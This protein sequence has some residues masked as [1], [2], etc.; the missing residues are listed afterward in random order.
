MT[1]KTMQTADVKDL[2]A[3]VAGF[4]RDGG[5]PRVKEIV[6]RFMHDVFQLIEDFDVSPEEFWQA[7]YYVNRLGQNGEAA[8]LAPGLGMDRYLDIRLDARDAEA[9]LAGGTPRTIE[10]PLYVAGAPL[11]EGYARMDDG[12]DESAEVMILTGRVTDADGQPLAGAVVDIWHANTMGNYSYFDPSQS[13]YNLRRRIRTDASG[14]YT[15][16]SIV[17]AGY[18]CPPD[19]STQALLNLLGRHGNRPAHIHF[20]ISSPGFKHLTTQINLAG[21]AYTYDDFAFAT[22]DELVIEG[23]RIDDP[24]RAEAFGLNAPFTLVEFDIEL[25]PTEQPELQTRHQ[26]PRALENETA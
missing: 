3:R 8:L 20:F 26:R 4:D 13:D 24:A 18:G 2:L 10:G 12:T 7:V 5:N 1:I 14:R 17:P 25:V 11:S 15:A 22:R 23:R 16:R 21:D 9:G 6:H 19:G